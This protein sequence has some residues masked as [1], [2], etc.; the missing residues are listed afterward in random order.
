[1]LDG[2]LGIP[3]MAVLLDA[4]NQVNRDMFLEHLVNCGGAKSFRIKEGHF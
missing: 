3:I 1:M 2:I 4:S